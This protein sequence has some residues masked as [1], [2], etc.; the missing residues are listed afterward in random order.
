M[1][2]SK[3]LSISGKPGLHKLLAQTKNGFVVESLTDGKRFTAF[4]HER[5][6]T[7]EE[8]SIFT[9]GEDMPLKDVMKAIFDKLNGGPAL[10]HK[11]NEPEIIAFFGE[12]IPT[13]DKEKVYISD[14]RKV[15]NWY[16]ILHE[17][18]MLE[19]DE[20]ADEEKP[21]EEK[22]LIEKPEETVHKKPKIPEP[23]KQV[24][25]AKIKA[26]PKTKKKV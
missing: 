23:K 10:S 1:E 11:A 19:F 7:L 21:V 18:K 17:H 15:I 6:S 26:A 5:V 14:I 13:Y 4:S 22:P 12:V 8:I 9:T 2:L 3:V 24:R 25:T 20:K 16:N